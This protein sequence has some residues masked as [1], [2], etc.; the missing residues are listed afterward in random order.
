MPTRPRPQT[1]LGG[2][3]LGGTH[4]GRRGSGAKAVP[5]RAGDLRPVNTVVAVKISTHHGP[6]PR[7]AASIE[8]LI[9]PRATRCV[10][11]V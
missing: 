6:P 9:T 3:P 5:S 2:T 7:H 1:I 4:L 8:A 11:G 10:E